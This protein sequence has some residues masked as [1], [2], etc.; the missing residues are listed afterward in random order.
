MRAEALLHSPSFSPLEGDQVAL[1]LLSNNNMKTTVC[2][3]THLKEVHVTLVIQE[4]ELGLLS[5]PQ[6]LSKSSA[7]N[8][9]AMGLLTSKG[10]PTDLLRQVVAT[11]ALGDKFEH[12]LTFVSLAG[13]P[14]RN[15]P[16]K[17]INVG[18]DGSVQ[19]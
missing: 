14:A 16:T 17:T 1:P 10:K 18:E 15:A 9:E 3:K 11:M 7:L 8:A 19:I 12:E 5:N 6:L 13:S 4:S 2:K